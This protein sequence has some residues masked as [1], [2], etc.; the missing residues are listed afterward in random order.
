[1]SCLSIIKIFKVHKRNTIKRGNIL[2]TTYLRTITHGN[3][4]RDGVVQITIYTLKGSIERQKEEKCFLLMSI[5]LSM[6]RISFLYSVIDR[7]ISHDCPL[8][9]PLTN[10]HFVAWNWTFECGWL[11]SILYPL[12]SF[13]FYT[14]QTVNNDFK[15]C[16]A[17]DLNNLK[18]FKICGWWYAIYKISE[19]KS[20]IYQILNITI[21]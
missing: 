1:M 11:C 5:C 13:L 6:Y 3:R 15:A 8:A 21:Q 17:Y 4:H 16:A 10:K 9:R 7:G 20:Y 19:T 14:L 12:Y 2:S 18:G